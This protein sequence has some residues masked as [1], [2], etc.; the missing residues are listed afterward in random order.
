MDQLRD[1]E[2]VDA[3]RAAVASYLE[4]VDGWEAAYRRYYRMPGAALPASPDMEAAQGEYNA[5]R[6]D[7]E[8]LLGRAHRLCLKHQLRNAFPGL[9]RI[10]LGGNAPQH[11]VDSAISRS[12][13][14]AA[15]DCL[16][17]LAAAC[18][19][20]APDVPEQE[21]VARGGGGWSRRGIAAAGVLGALA[22]AGI[23]IGRW[24]GAGA[25]PPARARMLPTPVRFFAMQGRP[26]TSWG[27]Y[28]YILQHGMTAHLERTG[29]LLS[30]E[31]TGPYM[32]P[33]T[34]P[35]IGDV[36]L[37]SAGRKLLESTGLRGLRFRPVYKARIV[38]LR[39]QD[40]DLTAKEPPERPKSGDPEDYILERPPNSA[41]AEEMGNI[42]ELVIPVGVK[43]GADI[44]RGDGSLMP[45]VSE[46]AK[47]HLEGCFGAYVQFEEIVV[48]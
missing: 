45:L 46:R 2:F 40:W 10:S 17:Q 43:N 24:R 11:R 19:G 20:W 27:D 7:L 29:R 35:G 25:S 33:I 32:P 41:I 38:E 4:A 15:M 23:A 6:R 13:R 1:H 26:L 37:N 30:L 42:W 9:L 22:L 39:W 5:R 36:V 12:E 21:E 3:L 47:A 48:K 14:S 44:F 31:R 8:Q 16:V 28:G 34:F 18:R